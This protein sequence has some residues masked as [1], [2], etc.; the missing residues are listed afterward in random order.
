LSSLQKKF[1][2]L[3]G[4]I[5]A[6]SLFTIYLV[7]H[8][9]GEANPMLNWYMQYVGVVGMAITKIV[10]STVILIGVYKL[11]LGEFT[12]KSLSWGIAAYLIIFIVSFSAQFII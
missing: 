1:L 5:I 11:D 12:D 2:I 8:G 10:V 6:D 9:H 3:L 7:T 4:I